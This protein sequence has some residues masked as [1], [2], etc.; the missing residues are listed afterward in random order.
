LGHI[1]PSSI[2]FASFMLLVKKKDGTLYMCIDYW[3][4]NKKTLKNRYLI[5][6]IYEFMDELRGDKYFSKI[7]L[8][9]GYHQICIR[10][11][12]I[13]KT[14]FHYHYG[15]FKFLV[16]HFGL[17]NTLATFESCMNH[18]SH[19]QLRCFLLVFFNDILI[20]SRT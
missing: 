7:D 16:M 2:P 9:S 20:Y 13:P 19:G 11:Q 10:E 4:P 6:H 1:R 18:V 14:T 15:H 12:D 5:P 8:H 17:N 3:A